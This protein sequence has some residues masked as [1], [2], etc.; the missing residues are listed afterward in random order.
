MLF[1]PITNTLFL[2]FMWTRT[3]GKNIPGDHIS[4]GCGQSQ[5][6]TRGGN[7]WFTFWILH[8][9]GSDGSPFF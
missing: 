1:S 6:I 4:S 3:S 2:I 5:L 9:K 8:E 7:D